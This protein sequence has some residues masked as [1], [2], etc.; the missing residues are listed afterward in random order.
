M[1]FPP[2]TPCTVLPVSP[3]MP[4]GGPLQKLNWRG[5]TPQKEGELRILYVHHRTI[6]VEISIIK[7]W[8]RWPHGYITMKS[9]GYIVTRLH[10][11]IPS[12]WFTSDIKETIKHRI[13]NNRIAFVCWKWICCVVCRCS[14]CNCHQVANTICIRSCRWK[15]GK[16]CWGL[17]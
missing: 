17:W 13:W 3:S 11:F 10:C 14:K 1:L 16:P 2:V 4:K 5:R 8:S 7:S 12:L 9:S 6:T 15:L